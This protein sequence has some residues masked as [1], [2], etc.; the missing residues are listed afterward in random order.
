V[1][2][3]ATDE[4]LDFPIVYASALQGY[5]TL[6]LD[7]PS[8]DL[9]P[10]F[11]TI[12]TSVK[13]PEVDLVGNL[14]MQISS[15]DYTSYLGLIGIGRIK[16]G[17][18]KPSQL[19]SIVD[20]EG[21]VRQG[22]IGQVLGYLGLDRTSIE[23]ADAGDIVAITGIADLT[24]SDT[25]CTRDQAEA[26]PPLSVDR[27]TISII[28]QVNDSPFAG[29][30]GKYV[31]SRNIRDR[32]FKEQTY[33]IA[34]KVEEQ[35]DPNKFLVSG[36]G[37][38]H[39]GVLIETMRREGFEL[40]ISKPKVILKEENGKLQEPYEELV[41][42]LPE[43]YQGAMMEALASRKGMLKNLEPDGKGRVRLDYIIPARGL[44]G[45]NNEFQNI[46]SGT[47]IL[48][49][50]FDHYGEHI[51]DL[52][53]E[54][55]KGVLIAN[56]GGTSNSFGLWNL[57]ARGRMFIGPQTDVYE[58]MIV[59]IHSRD[60]DLVVNVTKEKKLTNM[61]ASGTDES[62]VLTPPLKLSLEQ[63]MDFI[64]DDELVEV[65][66]QSIRLRKKYLKENERKRDGK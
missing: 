9:I 18:I 38:L 3:N 46:A 56:S 55:A 31:T 6:D 53:V 44:I 45:F 64:N 37:E 22:K 12:V 19:V 66:P 36:R 17:T 10:L 39:L 52:G 29:K 49:H 14:Q 2:L 51:T 40:S 54:R 28:I 16:R 57:Q 34:L 25:V 33:N 35:G 61:R 43:Q 4:Q 30:E 26:L 65:T 42:D 50:V 23:S 41:V 59:G 47:G 24:I 21:N 15:L 8:T 32:L 58:G 11:E 27:P 62:I 48:S 20:R 63:A 5:A 1:N 7:M 13:P 60:N